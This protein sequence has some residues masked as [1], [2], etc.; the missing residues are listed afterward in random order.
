[1]SGA[2]QLTSTALTI[3]I[4]PIALVVPLD[5]WEFTTLFATPESYV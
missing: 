1:M 2:T 4:T 3:R 5:L